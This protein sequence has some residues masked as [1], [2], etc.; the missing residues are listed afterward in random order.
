MS[1]KGFQKAIARAPQNLRVKLHMGETTSDPVYEDAESRFKEL[2]G[3]TKRLNEESTRYHNAVNSM[4]D[5]Q[6]GFANA[7]KEIYKPISGRSSDPNSTVPEGNPEGIEACE[8]YGELMSEL[9]DTLKPDLELIDTKIV[10]PAD[11]LLKIIQAIRKMA[12]KR[13]HKQLDLDRFQ[14]TLKKYQEKR[15]KAQRKDE[16]KAV[17]YEEKIYK[18]ENDV[19]VAQQEYDYYNEMMKTDLPALFKLES[20]FIEPL[21]VSLYYMQLNVFYTLSSKM[22]E[23]KIPYFNL[24]SDIIQEFNAKRGNVEER[25]DAIGVTHFRVTYSKSKLDMTRKRLAMEHGAVGAGAA[26]GAATGAALGA[27]QAGSPAAGTPAG[28]PPAYSQSTQ[29]AQPAY[30]NEKSSTYGQPPQY[31]AAQPGTGYSGQN[32]YQTPPT[33]TSTGYDQKVAPVAAA[34]AAVAPAVG[35]SS[36]AAAPAGASVCTAIYDY[37]AQARGDLTFKAGDKI[38]II[39]RTADQNGWWTGSINGATGV[40]PGNYVQLS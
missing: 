32:A 30:G 2:E 36:S 19:A 39:Q 31:Q 8:Q 17:K 13:N 26:T 4:L 27:S 3:E 15:D 24:S 35:A 23:M 40:F 14:N 21:F 33:S 38:T 16:T 6:I 25:A 11:E 20:E 5:R 12:T 28:P 10:K 29:P 22:E 9:K 37:T 7:I 1:F 34:A 18:A